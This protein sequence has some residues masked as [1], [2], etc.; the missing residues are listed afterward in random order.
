[1]LSG[2][3]WKAN[4]SME[5]FQNLTEVGDERMDFLE[6][7]LPRLFPN[8]VPCQYLSTSL[9]VVLSLPRHRTPFPPGQKASNAARQ[10]GTPKLRCS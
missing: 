8:Y 1:M 6:Y 4:S 10:S 7:L 3:S 5:K 9:S 2:M